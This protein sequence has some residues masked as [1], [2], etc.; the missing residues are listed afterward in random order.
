VA[1]VALEVEVFFAK[2]LGV[3]SGCCG[4]SGACSEG[5]R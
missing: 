2:L 4:W 1:V 3:G 5:R